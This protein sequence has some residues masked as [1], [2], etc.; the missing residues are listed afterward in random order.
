MENAGYE[1]EDPNGEPQQ[2]S[3]TIDVPDNFQEEKDTTKERKT[4]WKNTCLTACLVVT[5]ALLIA[6]LAAFAVVLWRILVQENNVSTG[7]WSQEEITTAEKL[8]GGHGQWSRFSSCS[9]SCGNGLKTRTRPC[10]LAS[11]DCSGNWEETKVCQENPCPVNG[12]WGQWS[13]WGDCNKTCGDGG[14]RNRTRSCNNPSPEHGGNE[15]PGSA[16]EHKTCTLPNCSTELDLGEACKPGYTCSDPNA[17]CRDNGDGEKCTCKAAFVQKQFNNA[18]ACTETTTRT[19]SVLI[20][21][22][23]MA[24]VMAAK[25]LNEA[26]ITDYII[27][28]AQPRLG[29][30]IS[31]IKWNGYTLEQGAAWIHG[32]DGN[33]MWD[34]AQKYNLSGFIT[35]YEDYIARDANGNDV[36]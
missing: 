30:R 13:G 34:L 26:G 28:E 10:I 11:D 20:L 27:I 4:P 12:N 5:V 32:L 14:V 25:T 8:Y 18:Q 36:T 33:P 24:G 9:V 3:S 19:A 16:V 23:G 35:D 2:A 15:C 29:G 21:G 31:D 6:A 17:E 22:G 7:G 1:Q